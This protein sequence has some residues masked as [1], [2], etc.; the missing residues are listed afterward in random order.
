MTVG[1]KSAGKG[2][3]ALE[4]Y[5]KGI[6]SHAIAERLG[7]PSLNTVHQLIHQAK[8]RRER[9]KAGEVAG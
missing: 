5:E 3:R 2:D 6:D 8:A 7:I 4:L 1:Q 9:V